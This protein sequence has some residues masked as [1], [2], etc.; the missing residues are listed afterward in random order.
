[1]AQLQMQ[2]RQKKE[3]RAG[4]YCSSGCFGYMFDST[5]RVKTPCDFCK[6]IAR[7]SCDFCVGVLKI[8]LLPYDYCVVF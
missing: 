2:L 7:S 1:M 6:D 4:G 8:T 5:V 3:N